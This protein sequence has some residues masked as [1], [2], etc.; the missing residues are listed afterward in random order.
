MQLSKYIIIIFISTH[1]LHA[2]DQLYFPP[3]NSGEWDTVSPGDLSWCTES[4][5]DLNNVLEDN[6]TRAFIVLKNGKIV[7]EQYFNGFKRDSSWI[8][9]SAGKTLTAC[10]VGLAQEQG[11]LHINDSSSDYLGQGWS[12]LDKEQEEAISIRH[13]LTMSTGL[14]YTMEDNFCTDPQCL[15]Y[16]NPPGSHWYYH[17]APYSLLRNIIE[18]AT[19]QNLTIYS[20]F[21]LQQKIG[22]DGIWIRSGFNNFFI[23]TPRSMARF[24]LF[25]LNNGDWNGNVIMQDKQYFSDMHN[26]SQDLNP[27]YGYLWWLNGKQSYKLPASDIIYPGTLIDSAPSDMYCAIGASGQILCIS[28]SQSLVFMR[29][30]TSG[31]TDLVPI[32]M[33]REISSYLS[34]ILCDLSSDVEVVDDSPQIQ[35][36]PNP[37]L[38]GT[39]K[40]RGLPEGQWNY[41]LLDFRGRLIEKGK[42]LHTQEIKAPEKRGIYFIQLIQNRD[43][44]TKRIFVS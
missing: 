40:F 30:G 41:Q 17:N 26:S 4:I 1:F 9:F 28:P 23:S 18:N 5:E 19:N 22:M 24:G 25:M 33:V 10:L 43:I 38:N 21:Q 7:I 16:L 37:V 3:N 27:A 35:I 11:L 44:V 6:G 8:W 2:Q 15:E 34:D 31:F 36:F 32:D 13:H 39:I 42:I 14:D 29:M 20:F 12:S